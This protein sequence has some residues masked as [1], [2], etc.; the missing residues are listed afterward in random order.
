MSYSSSSWPDEPGV[1]LF[2]NSAGEIIYIGQSRRLKKR[3]QS[4]FQKRQL[5]SKT[6]Q[7]VKEIDEIEIITVTSTLSKTI[8]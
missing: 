2:K 1:Y 4:Y 8:H 6:S 5:G 7:M 3:L